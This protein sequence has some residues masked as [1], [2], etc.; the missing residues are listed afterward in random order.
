[1]L[2]ITVVKR[3]F[4]RLRASSNGLARSGWVHRW[5][6][7]RPLDRERIA[8]PAV[9]GSRERIATSDEPGGEAE[10]AT[11]LDVYHEHH[12]NGTVRMETDRGS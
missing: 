3:A 8:T 12:G 10:A 6:H 9:A 4:E 11:L 1:L 2:L 5:V 7:G